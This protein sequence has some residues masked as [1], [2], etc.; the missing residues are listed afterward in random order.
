LP[1]SAAQ[2][3]P[4]RL[5]YRGLIVTLSNPAGG[6]GSVLHVGGGAAW[7]A[8]GPTNTYY[9]DPNRAL[10]TWL[11]QTGQPSLPPDLRT[12]VQ[13]ELAGPPSP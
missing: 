3:Y 1:A 2:A 4:D 13:A 8:L 5:G 12:T 7:L 10:E 9:A 11:L 6:Q